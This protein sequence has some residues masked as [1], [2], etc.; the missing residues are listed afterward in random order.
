MKTLL[1]ALQFSIILLII[2]CLAVISCKPT[3][4]DPEVQIAIESLEG[5]IRR[6]KIQLQTD[7]SFFEGYL[8]LVDD[9]TK[10]LDVKIHAL[11]EMSKILAHETEIEEKIINCQVEIAKL[12]SKI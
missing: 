10:H 7:S 6:Y 5:Q 12:K 3:S 4:P 8:K 1:L 9:S 11:T 2:I